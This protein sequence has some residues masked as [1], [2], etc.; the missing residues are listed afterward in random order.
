MDLLKSVYF[1]CK[2]TLFHV[3]SAGRGGGKMNVL[4][5]CSAAE[6]PLAMAGLC[7][8]ARR[9]TVSPVPSA[10]VTARLCSQQPSAAV[11]GG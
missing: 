2:G 9:V 11:P 10:A 6:Q 8:P 5:L 1:T 4:I 7:R 3:G